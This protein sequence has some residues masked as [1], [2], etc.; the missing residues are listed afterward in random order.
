MSKAEAGM[1]PL[2]KRLGCQTSARSRE[3]ALKAGARRGQ[4][5]YGGAQRSRA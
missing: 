5:R 3:R 2:S 1:S 4:R